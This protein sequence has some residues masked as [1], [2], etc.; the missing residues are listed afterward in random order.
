MREKL[1]KVSRA[2]LVIGI[3]SI[4][5]GVSYSTIT[6]IRYI[7]LNEN[8]INNCK[9]DV[10]FKEGKGI[11]LTN[12][13]P[14]D[15]VDAKNISP[16][17]FYIKNNNSSC[18]NLKYKIT[19]G[20][21]C[22][23]DVIDDDFISYELVNVDTG[24]I[25]RGDGINTLNDTFKIRSGSID[26]YEMRIWIN[27]K[28]TNDDL[29]VDGDPYNS[30]KY[31]GK[32]NA[33]VIA[34]SNTLKDMLLYNNDIVKEEP[35]L[36]N[37]YDGAGDKSGLYMSTDTNSGNPTYYFRG[38]NGCSGVAMTEE[39]CTLLGGTTFN[40]YA[41][42]CKNNN[43][44]YYI[45]QLPEEQC[46]INGGTYNENAVNNYVKFAGF[47]WRIV[48]INED[49]SIRLLLNEGIN[50]TGYS[51]NSNNDDYTY[52]Y[53]SN[54]DVEGGVKRTVDTWYNDNLKNYKNYIVNTEF[55]EQYKS[56]W[57]TLYKAG[58]EKTITY[59]NYISNF[60]CNTDKNGRGLLKLDV[61]LLSYDEAIHAGNYPGR[62]SFSYIHNG[63]FHLISPNGFYSN[64]NTA[65]T[66][67]IIKDGAIASLS[68]DYK[69]AMV[70]PVISLK[71]D[72]IV[73][74]QGT[75][76]DPYVVS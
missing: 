18:D 58:N 40:S 37:S 36:T 34:Y 70:L 22:A 56:S 57:T 19:M 46:I 53:Y 63:V 24:E 23:G 11:S 20:N 12:T 10:S 17:T 25:I 45:K 47:T 44:F 16:Y 49:G 31:C 28:A 68:T 76:T 61:G 52:M 15:Y 4:I 6:G 7:G 38:N 73:T 51:F 54:S 60:K 26:S 27:E 71:A 69:N 3:I 72:V 9:I 50:N 59:G 5:V 35:T 66:W 13:Y 43:T 55:C 29:Y 74:G 32:L 65:N 67:G 64:I 42:S 21:T 2:L 39:I 41:L 62:P 8:K 75:E 1:I 33:E 14:M 30:K 48:R